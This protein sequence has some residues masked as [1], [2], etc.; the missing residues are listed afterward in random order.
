MVSTDGHAARMRKILY[1]D[2]D[3]VLVDFQSAVPH[4]S[5]DVLKEYKDNLDEVPGVFS[6]MAPL[7]GAIDA[8]NE[9]SQ[10]FDAYILSTAPW[11]NPSAWSDKLLWVKRHLGAAAHKRLILSHHKN[12]NRGDFLVDDRTK[13]GA[14]EFEGMHIQFGT[15]RFP[16]WPAVLPFLRSAA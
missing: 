9:L 13:H 12:L 2:M 3:N 16:D 4:L 11:E 6:L 10:L 14:G 15:A 5:P 7:P 8:F 1:F